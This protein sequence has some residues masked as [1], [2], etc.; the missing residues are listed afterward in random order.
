MNPR[1]SHTMRSRMPFFPFKKSGTPATG[2][3]IVPGAH[4]FTTG[5]EEIFMPMAGIAFTPAAGWSPFNGTTGDQKPENVRIA[6]PTLMGK[7]G[8]ITGLVFPV[9]GQS[10]AERL[11]KFLARINDR[12]VER[13]ETAAAS[14]IP[15]IYLHTAGPAPGGKIEGHAIHCFFLNAAGHVIDLYCVGSNEINARVTA[16]SFLRTLRFAGGA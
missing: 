1:A 5:S 15:V 16:D 11:E 14:G 9:D 7:A 4:Q 13:K 6:N 8:S 3:T 12:V 10:P 2:K